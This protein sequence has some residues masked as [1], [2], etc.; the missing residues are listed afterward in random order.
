MQ[1][2]GV[3]WDLDGVLVD[4]LE[5]HLGAWAT[6][7]SESGVDHTWEGLKATFGRNNT[8]ALEMILGPGADP[9][10]VAEI[11][12]R[13]E[14]LFRQ[15]ARGAVQ[16]LPGAREWLGRLAEAGVRQ[17]IATSAPLANIAIQVD[18][19]GLRGY[20]AAIVSGADLPPKPD[21]AVYL[22]AARAI[23][24]PPERCVVVE[25]AVAGVEGARRAGMKCVAVATTHPA[26]ALRGAEVVVARLDLLPL[27]TF[28]RL[29]RSN[30]L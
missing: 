13:K 24:V 22:Q 30:P 26:E 21:P 5:L 11:G 29:S 12:E 25:D 18:G 23:G 20:F 19:L 15:R 16:T 8:A 1:V 10:R 6:V 3:L 4:S 9:E 27:D 7:L 28:D 14:E 2:R 17:A